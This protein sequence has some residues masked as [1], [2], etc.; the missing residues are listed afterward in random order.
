MHFKHKPHSS[1]KF[2]VQPKFVELKT[3]FLVAVLLILSLNFD[4]AIGAQ[5]SK[6][7]EIKIF[8]RLVV[9]SGTFAPW[10]VIAA[11]WVCI[12]WRSDVS[13]EKIRRCVL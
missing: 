10:R 4:A 1:V 8:D 12:G 7:L 6:S 5:Q 11:R 13:K 2:A 9:V 3:E